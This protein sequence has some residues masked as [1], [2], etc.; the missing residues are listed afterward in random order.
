VP[1][2]QSVQSGAPSLEYFPGGH[3]LGTLV[4]ISQY[5][6]AGHVKHS[7]AVL[8]IS[9]YVPLGQGIG[10]GIPSGQ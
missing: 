9:L 5:L 10:A 7:L 8:S 4:P 1:T 2:S 3:L 6:P